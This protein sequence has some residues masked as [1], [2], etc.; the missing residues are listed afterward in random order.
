MHEV[1]GAK[2]AGSADWGGEETTEQ[3]RSGLSHA[4]CERRRCVVDR[5][6]V[7]SAKLEAIDTGGRLERDV[8]IRV[9][10]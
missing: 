2:S 7:S 5:A 9:A 4:S 6:S 8:H 3:P 1:G 10:S